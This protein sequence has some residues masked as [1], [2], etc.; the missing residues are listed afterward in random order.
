MRQG[1]A[2]RRQGER[3][4]LPGTL[5]KAT[6][7]R[8]TA[9]RFGWNAAGRLRRPGV[10]ILLYHRIGAPGDPFPGLDVSVFR[11]Q[12]E[13]LAAHCTPISPDQL[14]DAVGAGSL[15]RPPVLVTFDDGYLSYRERAYPILREFGIPSLL[16]LTT[17]Y[18][19]EPTRLFWWDALRAAIEKA[20]C[21]RVELPWDPGSTLTVDRPE[22]R[23]QLL[24]AAKEHLKSV[25]DADRKAEV[26]ELL[27]RL[28]AH[29]PFFNG[30]RQMLSWD[31]VTA[32][33]EGTHIGGHSHTHPIMSMLTD[34]ALETEVA[35]CRERIRSATGMTP[36]WFA[37][38]NGRTCDFDDRSRAALLRHGFDSAFA[39]VG[40]VA[41]ADVD[42]MA[43]PRFAGEG[44]VGELAWRLSVRARH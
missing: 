22:S 44:T 18:I 15:A 1:D 31:D 9:T 16:F 20:A 13:W 2:E 14:R 41:G 26:A 38:P 17:A 37:Y 29:N 27:E 11:A 5:A 40:G 34:E 28:G 24:S 33:L 7:K 6:I 4:R 23:Q 3:V 25:P 43:L 30:V 42:W 32:I 35:T 19:D 8:L 10:L 21:R 36:R 39:S 12:M